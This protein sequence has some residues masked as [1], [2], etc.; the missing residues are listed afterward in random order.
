MIAAY[1]FD[2]FLND[3][4]WGLREQK[5]LTGQAEVGVTAR[6]GAVF[7]AVTDKGYVCAGPIRTFPGTLRTYVPGGEERQDQTRVVLVC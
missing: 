4:R 2:Y 1:L 3:G 6:C 7:F 5:L